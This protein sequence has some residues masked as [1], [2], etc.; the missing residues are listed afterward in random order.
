MQ[1]VN[2]R[3]VTVQ[4]GAESEGL[5]GSETLAFGGEGVSLSALGDSWSLF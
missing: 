2:M 5:L 4:L 1:L 3:A